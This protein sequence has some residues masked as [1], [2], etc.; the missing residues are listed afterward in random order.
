MREPASG[1]SSPAAA[2]PAPPRSRSTTPRDGCRRDRRRSSRRRPTPRPRPR[3]T[4]MPRARAAERNGDHPGQENRPAQ[5]RRAE[6]RD[7]PTLVLQRGRGRRLTPPAPTGDGPAVERSNHL[8]VVAAEDA[9][10]GCDQ[11]QEPEQRRRHAHALKPTM[12][13]PEAHR[14]IVRRASIVSRGVG[15][16][17]STAATAWD[18]I[19]AS[20]RRR[21]RRRSRDW[22]SR[23]SR[24]R[25][26][27][28]GGAPARST[29]AAARRAGPTHPGASST[30]C[31][32]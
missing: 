16:N 17:G 12:P 2:R 21:P 13:E 9:G 15:L 8:L 30:C 3:Y 31:S 23:S 7:G 26:R 28:A 11:E 24:R 27:R 6:D 22:A 4:A 5:H 29:R 14:S 10:V 25:S 1:T 32:M 18:P 20:A 19:R